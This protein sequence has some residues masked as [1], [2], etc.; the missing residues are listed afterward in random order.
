MN[1]NLLEIV[2][3]N[4][5]VFFAYLVEFVL[6]GIVAILLATIIIKYFYEYLPERIYAKKRE[7]AKQTISIHQVNS[8][9]RTKVTKWE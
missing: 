9:S 6:F 3:M 4:K 1:A 5:G 2:W 8:E 7:L